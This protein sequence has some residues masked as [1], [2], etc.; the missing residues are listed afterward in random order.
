MILGQKP[1][2]EPP[3]KPAAT[4][5]TPSPIVIAANQS[6]GDQM[7]LGAGEDATSSLE[8]ALKPQSSLW[9]H[10]APLLSSTPSAEGEDVQDDRVAEWHAKSS[11]TAPAEL[12]VI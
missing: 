12:Q 3:P 11:R 2:R 7:A 4:P 6:E 5:G 9:Q 8:H 1:L 10:P